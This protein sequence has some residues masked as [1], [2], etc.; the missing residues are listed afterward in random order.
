M[1]LGPADLKRLRLPLAAALLLSGLGVGAVLYSEKNLADA[2]KLKN[3][4]HARL[5]ATRDRLTKVSQEE[6]EIR[7]N[8]VQFKQ[9]E[10]RGMAGAEKR[11]E[12]IEALAA[13]RQKRRLFQV[14]YYL[15]SQRAVD[16]PGVA[17]DQQGASAIF[18][19][20]R[21]KLDLSLLHEEDLLNFLADLSGSGTFASL[22]SCSITRTE[23]A[24]A[25]GG[26]LRPRLRANC[27]IDMITLKAR[28]KT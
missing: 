12:W 23:R 7:N 6:Q 27:V 28:D 18:I 17:Q 20:N 22:R 13:V 15:D 14:Q 5:V 19:A 25:G 16:Y 9:F 4:G 26:P 2:E 1:M 3:E 24:G 8:L 10:E 21:V 11:L